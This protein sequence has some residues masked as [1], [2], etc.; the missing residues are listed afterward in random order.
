VPAR[1][2]RAPRRRQPTLRARPPALR[3]ARGVRAV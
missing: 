2:L 3:E 1:P